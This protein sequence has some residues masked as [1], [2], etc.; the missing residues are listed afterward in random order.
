MFCCFLLKGQ[1]DLKYWKHEVDAKRQITRHVLHKE[2]NLVNPKS[3]AVY[4][5]RTDK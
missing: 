3:F 2:V 1:E 4:L 5:R